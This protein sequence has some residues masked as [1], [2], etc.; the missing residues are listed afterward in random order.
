MTAEELALSL[1][2]CSILARVAR[3]IVGVAGELALKI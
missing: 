2:N 1:A 3:H